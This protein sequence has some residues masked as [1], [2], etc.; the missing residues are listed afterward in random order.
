[1]DSIPNELTIDTIRPEYDAMFVVEQYHVLSQW[2]MAVSPRHPIMFYAIQHSLL[3][4][5]EAEDTQRIGAHVKTGPH[6]LHKAFMDFRNDIGELVEP[7]G[8]GFKPVWQG[9]FEGT[10]NR[11]ITV[12]GVGE[13]ENQYV[14][15]SAIS[16]VDRKRDYA[17]I[18]MTHFS[19]FTKPSSKASGKTCADAILD[20][21]TLAFRQQ[22]QGA[23]YSLRGSG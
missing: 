5:L 18:G 6:A 12:L 15:R 7:L 23:Y 11:T 10:G 16:P 3:N 8:A 22:R 17:A 9:E 14:Q 1:M 2:F 21:I 4:L 20:D 19:T 13:N